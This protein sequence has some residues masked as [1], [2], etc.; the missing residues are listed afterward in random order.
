MFGKVW[1]KSLTEGSSGLRKEMFARIR[2]TRS[3]RSD[4]K[5]GV[6]EGAAAQKICNT[7]R[8]TT[9]WIIRTAEIIQAAI[10]VDGSFGFRLLRI[11]SLAFFIHH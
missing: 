9:R 5:H 4:N 10:I 2:L 11:Q 8:L 3:L 6:S 7:R 1:N